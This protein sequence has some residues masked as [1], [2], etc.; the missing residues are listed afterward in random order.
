MMLSHIA[1]VYAISLLFS[2][3]YSYLY[4]HFLLDSILIIFIIFLL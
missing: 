1:R 4:F 3:R 2:I